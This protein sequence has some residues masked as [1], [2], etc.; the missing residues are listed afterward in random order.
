MVLVACE[1]SQII[2]M[3][4]RSLGI[5]AFSC[6]IQDCS[7]GHPEYHIK[8]DCFNIIY[9]SCWDLIIS[10]PP[11]T[12]LCV[13]GA[14]WFKRKQELGI[15]QKSIEFFL[16]FTDLPCKHTMIENPVGIMSN[17][18]RKPDQIIQPYWFG[19]P[20]SKKTCL[21]LKGL[22]PLMATCICQ[23]Y[24]QSI[25]KMGS[26]HSKERSKTFPGIASAIANQWKSYAGI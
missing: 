9:D 6:D 3:A 19:D 7:G 14:R 4:F 16:K 24:N 17:I 1:E 21:W 18:Y 11:C 8:D 20:E 10:H 26:N 13:S 22:P 25:W 23:D 5:N 2:T 15:Q 12:D